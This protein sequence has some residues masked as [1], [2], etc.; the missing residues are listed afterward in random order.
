MA[1]YGTD[2]GLNAYAAARGKTLTQAAAALLQLATDYLETLDY[3]GT[4]VSEGQNLK[5]PR[6][7]IVVDG[8]SLDT[9]VVPTLVENAAYAQALAIDAGNGAQNVINPAV[10]REKLDVMEVEYQ[11]GAQ[12][13]AID[14]VTLAILRP[15]IKSD[16][17]GSTFAVGR[18]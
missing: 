7:G 12:A 3:K 18:A 6:Y 9:G 13:N 11:D 16:F 14:P 8:V 5:W 2:A 10:K 17:G 15:V 1:V 4:R